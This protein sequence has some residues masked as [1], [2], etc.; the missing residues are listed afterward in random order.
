MKLLVRKASELKAARWAGGTTTQLAIW[1][2]GTEYTKFNFQ[3]RIS[4]ATVE[5]EESTFTFMPG[6]KRHLMI[7][8]GSLRID[9]K[10]RYIKQLDKFG[11]DIFDGEW[12]T[13]AKGKVSDFNLMTR[14]KTSGKL[15]ALILRDRNET[16]LDYGQNV[17]HSSYFVASGNVRLICGSYSATL[18]QGDFA[19]IEHEN[20]NAII[21]MQAIADSEIVVA[22]VK[23]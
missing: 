18:N 3:F 23:L 4:K 22:S 10:G 21:H 20:E 2:E 16:T 6:V 7:L 15:Q 8:D 19:F 1:P 12:P 5:V 13:T 11:Y 17:T 14:G 9:H